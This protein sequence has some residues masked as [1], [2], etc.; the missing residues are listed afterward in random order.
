MSN[1]DNY[2]S[3]DGSSLKEALT[4]FSVSVKKPVF[5]PSCGIK[6]NEFS[7]YCL[8]C[9]SDLQTM[10]IQ[11][12][13]PGSVISNDKEKNFNPTFQSGD[14]KNRFISFFQDYLLN[15]GKLLLVV[16][17][18]SVGIGVSFLI[19]FLFAFIASEAI[20]TGLNNGLQ[21]GLGDF[22][23]FLPG[24]VTF[25]NASSILLFM[26]GI[27]MK[28]SAS[29]GNMISMSLNFHLGAYVLLLLLSLSFI[30][31]GFI[32]GKRSKDVIGEELVLY[33]VMA[34][35]LNV[36]FLM[37]IVLF[38]QF[39]ET[40]QIEFVTG[41]ISLSFSVFDIVVKGFFIAF[42]LHMMGM[43]LSQKQKS[44]KLSKVF[45][46]NFKYGTQIYYAI[47]TFIWG[48]SFLFLIMII[49][50]MLAWSDF[51]PGALLLITQLV[52]YFYAM[53]HFSNFTFIGM[54]SGEVF[55]T[56][57][58]IFNY[59]KFDYHNDIWG[60]P[61]YGLAPWILFV[62]ISVLVVLFLW[63]GYQMKKKYSLS[64]VRDIFIFGVVYAT[65]TGFW[66]WIGNLL[67]RVSGNA[68]QENLAI[69]MRSETNI[70]LY[71]VCALIFSTL[72][73]YL[74]TKLSK[75]NSN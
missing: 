57:M 23:Y 38:A 41:K 10:D 50:S 34:G 65:F 48:M 24:E 45:A 17:A 20:N 42:F 36:I 56:S 2:C 58:N 14:S 47:K 33:S 73:A 66:L 19:N 4:S 72:I 69:S 70:F 59:S 35:L 39:S 32:N 16:K 46:D 49:S 40:V 6:V 61:L 68:F 26:H 55:N 13:A 52:A 15:P 54:E 74:G 11:L 9:G 12:R 5:C 67:F 28:L 43:L 75:T 22:W 60:S 3:N 27:M 71:L 63:V 51:N 30:V 7:N 8:S 53:I 62:G 64:S 21:S 1:H 31:G 25:I 18:I 37:I 29:A 44:R